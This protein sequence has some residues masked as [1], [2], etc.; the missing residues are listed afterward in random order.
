MSQVEWVQHTAEPGGGLENMELSRT[1][2]TAS[3]EAKGRLGTMLAGA[4]V[5]LLPPDGDRPTS[6]EFRLLLFDGDLTIIDSLAVS[7]SYVARTSSVSYSSTGPKTITGTETKLEDDS[8]V[9]SVVLVEHH[10]QGRI[11]VK[12]HAH[13]PANKPVAEVLPAMEFLAMMKYAKSFVV[14]PRWAAIPYH[15]AVDITELSPEFLTV[16]KDW[17]DLASSLNDIQPQSKL[18]MQFPNLAAPQRSWLNVD[19]LNPLSLDGRVALN[20]FKK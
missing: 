19:T 17:Y 12:F 10:Q 4:A 5:S 18:G 6:R 9:L 2:V 13:A 15:E 8:G 1:F 16:V 7:T 11:G 14:Y 20:A 3:I